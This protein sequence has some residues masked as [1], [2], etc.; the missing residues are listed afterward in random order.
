MR[1]C[2]PSPTKMRPLTD[3]E[4]QTLFQKLQVYLYLGKNVNKLIEPMQ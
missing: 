3:D 1:R 4:F 2:S